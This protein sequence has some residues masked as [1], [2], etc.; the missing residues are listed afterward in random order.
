MQAIFSSDRNKLL[1]KTG[2]I[3]F[4]FVILLILPGSRNSVDS[5]FEYL[6]S[7]SA[8]QPK[9]DT[10]IVIITISPEDINRIGP[11]PIKRSY[12]ALLLNSLS[13]YGVKAAGLE[14]FLSSRLTTQA[15]Y[16]N[17][18]TREINNAGNVVLSS[19][20]GGINR[21]NNKF[22]TDSL[23]HSTP[24]LIND[25]IKSGHI[26]FIDDEGIIIPLKIS[27]L[28]K[29]EQAF[30]FV[31][32]GRQVDYPDDAVII[33]NMFTSWKN[34][35]KYTLLEYFNLAQ[36]KD[37]SL[38][39]LK[40]K[41]VLTGINDPQIAP[42]FESYLEKDIPGVALH[43]FALDNLLNFRSY[44]TGVLFISKFIFLAFVLF[45][46]LIHHKIKW[47]SFFFYFL[48]F[49]AFVFITFVLFKF[50]HLQLSYS[51][52]IIPLFGLIAANSI[53]Y[54][55]EKKQQLKVV[56]DESTAL[57]NL[58]EQ[59]GIQLRRLEKEL[60]V[61][62]GESTGLLIDR[63]KLL[64]NEIDKIKKDEKDSITFTASVENEIKE[65]EGIIYRSGVM[66]NVVDMVKK[67]APENANILIVGDSGTGKELVA[68]AIHTLSKRKDK[69]FITV[70]C[71]ALSETLLESELFGH[72]KGAFTGAS[73]DK[74]GRF[75][76]ADK[77]T[78]FL[79]EIAETSEN[80]Q[81]KLLR[82]VQSGNFERVGSSKTE[83]ADV[84]I[85]AATNKN[86]EEAVKERKFRED[87]YYRLNVIKIELPPL[88]ERRD[89]IIVLAEYFLSKEDSE[90]KL[91]AASADALLNYEWRGNIR[92]LEA[93][94]KRAAIFS[95]SSGK[96]LIQ[97]IDFPDD[98]VKGSKFSFDD[99]VI[100]SLR[101][102]KFSHSSITETAKELGNVSRT[103][104]SENFRG[105][106]LKTYV[107]NN[108]EKETTISKIAASDDPVI[109]K[110]VE[111][112]L[113]TFISNI[114]NDV[115]RSGLHDFTQ[116]K[117]EFASKYKNLPQRFHIY[118]DETIRK[119][120]TNT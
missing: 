13:Q 17:L 73:T 44:R 7:L 41:I 100:E 50:F 119:L 109:L 86:L 72:V 92:E 64:K 85:V 53:I 48:S 67:S 4:I 83:H 43:A 104:V 107:E 2:F 113:H 89:D 97:L 82:V 63:I 49:T 117:I 62:P 70:N 71:G 65:F 95:R 29:T 31:L 25:K 30:S 59:K 87:L 36:Q 111:A 93:V 42:M 94:I 18:L 46:L 81:V 38:L 19:V 58:L 40:D 24:K 78:I 14:V 102:K 9:P 16:D 79:D 76:A 20:A 6:Y 91:S 15:I 103:L 84:R 66:E 10:N 110:K 96:N 74:T 32:S 37:S 105:V 34:F 115:A 52:F 45:I 112:K 5:G 99:L 101:D 106:V 35:K 90:M 26:N 80:F 108:F 55:I 88:R 8:G 12:Y 27:G 1:I 22:T 33:L 68:N 51:S 120:I 57:K 39:S 61:S 47:G 60:N 28:Q 118:L 56:L 3:V 114:E 116:V 98:I 11:W 77:G 54:T 23:S 69:N 75:Q 21:V